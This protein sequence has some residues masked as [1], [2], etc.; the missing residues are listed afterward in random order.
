MKTRFKQHSSSFKN[1]GDVYVLQSDQAS[2]GVRVELWP[3]QYSKNK[4]EFEKNKH[5]FLEDGK[6]QLLAMRIFVTEILDQHLRERMEGALI[7]GLYN[8]KE[9]WAKLADQ[10]MH[11]LDPKP[12][13][14][15][16]YGYPVMAE[17]ICPFKIYGLPDKLKI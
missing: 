10:G 8:S 13:E 3:W 15:K 12:G 17:N 5:L 4:E 6:K 16:Y 7:K 2:K 9:P 14:E 1:G 11:F